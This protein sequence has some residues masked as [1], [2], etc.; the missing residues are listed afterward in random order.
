MYLSVFDVFNFETFQSIRRTH[1][2]LT[3]DT[4]D[5]LC[6]VEKEVRSPA[7]SSLKDTILSR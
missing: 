3:L 6:F 7:R 5:A 2:L 1:T 4:R